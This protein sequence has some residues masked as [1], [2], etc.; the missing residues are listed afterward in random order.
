MGEQGAGLAVLIAAV[1][2]EMNEA[3]ADMSRE[4]KQ[5]AVAKLNERGAFHYRKAVED[6]ADSLGVSRFTVYNNLNARS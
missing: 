4:H 5:V 6:T 1:E 2:A 3:L